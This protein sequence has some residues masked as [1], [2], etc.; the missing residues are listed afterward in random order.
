MDSE[1]IKLRDE[2]EEARKN[3]DWEKSDELRNKINNLGYEIK[4]TQNG[5]EIRR[6]Q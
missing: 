4:D 6:K 2:R 5:P 3:K 1:V